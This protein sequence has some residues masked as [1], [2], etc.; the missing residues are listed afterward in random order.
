MKQWLVLSLIFSGAIARDSGAQQVWFRESFESGLGAWTASGPWNLESSSDPCGAT[1]GPFPSGTNAAWY[2]IDGPCTYDTPGSPNS[3]ALQLND[4]IDLPANAASISLRYWASSKT[5]DCGEGYDSMRVRIEA[6]NGPD[7]GFVE[8]YCAYAPGITILDAAWHERRLDLGAYRGAR[9]RVVFEFDTLDDLNNG[10]RGWLVDDVRILVEPGVRVCPPITF[11]SACPCL[12]NWL[13]IAGG[14]RNSTGQSATLHSEGVPSLTA[15]TLRLRAVLLP[16]ST[17]A[18]LV[19]G[20]ASIAPTVFG[21]GLRCVGGPL[22]RLGVVSAS[23]GSALWPPAGT[24]PISVL[25]Q[26]GG[27][28]SARFYFTY[29]RDVASYCTAAQFNATDA[30]RID[31]AP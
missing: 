12:P 19:Q 30:Q 15:D 3:G 2:G 10:F 22:I 21:D 6:Q 8:P 20:E 17:N 7:A 28:G 23:G 13:T 4:W 31:W 27:P 25:G 29:Y 1:F 16:A 26:L 18:L 5:E 9:V 14:C 11:G 24:S